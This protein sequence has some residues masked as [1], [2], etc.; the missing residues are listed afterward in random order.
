[1]SQPI[2]APVLS[3]DGNE[4]RWH[5]LYRAAAIAA[6]IGVALF[7]F[8][9][10]AFFVWPPPSTVAGH[11]ALLRSRPGQSRFRD[12]RGR[13]PCDPALFGTVPEPAA[14]AR[15]VDAHRH[16]P[17]CGV[18]YLLPRRYTRFEHA[19]PQPAVRLGHYGCGSGR[20]SGRRASGAFGLAGNAVSGGL[21][22]RIDRHAAR[23]V[24]D[25]AQ[26]DLQQG[27]GVCGNRGERSW[28]W[29]STCPRSAFTSRYSRSWGSDL[30]RPDRSDA[31]APQ[32]WGSG[33]RNRYRYC[34]IT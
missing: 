23:W 24:G 12:H 1:M 27:H 20:A 6:L 26:P 14:R 9:I 3:S 31:L 18:H 13:G 2:P 29:K 7:L 25:A 34:E 5:Y 30:V 19:V 21:C 8:Q 11:F 17:L 4:G 22:P 33:G 16:R 32:Q 28:F 10:V 15:I